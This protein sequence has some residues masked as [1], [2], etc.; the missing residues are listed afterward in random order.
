MTL[1]FQIGSTKALASLVVPAT[2]VVPEL[3]ARCKG[4]MTKGG[5]RQRKTMTAQAT[6]PLIAVLVREAAKTT[7]AI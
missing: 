7:G 1:L 4:L 3:A 5:R 2:A 6:K